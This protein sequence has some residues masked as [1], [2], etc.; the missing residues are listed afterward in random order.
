MGPILLVSAAHLRMPRDRRTDKPGAANNRL[1]YMSSMLSW[2]VERN[3]IRCN[4]ARDVK[5]LRYPTDGFHTWTPDEVKQF[6]VHY[7]VGT[8]ARLALALM[9][10]TGARRNDVVTLSRQHVRH[11]VIR[12]EP[13]KTRRKKMHTIEIPVAPE[14]ARIIVATPTGDMTFLMTEWGKPFTANG[15]GNWFRDRCNDAGLP[16]CGRMAYARPARPS[17]PNAAQPIVS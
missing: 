13:Q 15:F 16:H 4:P 8:K 7:P 2:A 9:L 1:K 3:L 6:E 10:F 12:F 11:G 17:Q 5:P 14:L